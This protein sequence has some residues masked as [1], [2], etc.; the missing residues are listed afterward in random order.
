[1]LPATEA[2]AITTAGVTQPVTV[3]GGNGGGSAANQLNGASGVF[4]D[5][6]GDVYVADGGNNRV[7]EWAPGATSGVTVARADL[8]QYRGGTPPVSLFVD[9]SGDVYVPD[10]GNNR[11]QE[12]KPDGTSVTAA[13]VPFQSFPRAVFVDGSGDVYV[14]YG[15]GVQEW[16]PGATSGVTVIGGI[17]PQGL[18]VDGSGDVYVDPNGRLVQK[19]APGATSGVTVASG[20]GSSDSFSVDASGDVFVTDADGLQEW[21]PGA[22]SG[23]TVAPVGGSVFVDNSGDVYVDRGDRVQEWKI[24]PNGAP[25]VT[26]DPQSQPVIGG[27]NVSFNAGVLAS[28]I[29][30]VQWQ[31]STDGGSTWNDIS[32]ATSSTYTIFDT[33][34]SDNGYEFRA[35]FTNGA[36]SVATDPATLSVSPSTANATTEV[37]IPSTG[38][39]LSGT[40]AVL[41]ASASGSNGDTIANVGYTLTGGTN[42]QLGG[43]PAT[44]T[45]YGYLG[46]IDTTRFPNGTY[47]LQ[48]VATDS[49]GGTVYSPP[50]TVTVN[51]PTPTT[52]VLLPSNGSTVSGSVVLDAIASANA[53]QV[54]FKLDGQTIASA[55]GSLWGRYAIWNSA[56]VPNG[57]YRL[58]SFASPSNQGDPAAL[59]LVTG[60]SAPVTITVDN[61]PPMSSVLLPSNGATVSGGSVILDAVAAGNAAGNVTRVDFFLNGL[62]ITEAPYPSLWGWYADWNSAKVPN[63]TYTLQSE[64]FNA[65]PNVDM[66]APVTITVA[67]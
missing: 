2:S 25:Q 13:T 34:S 1:V 7:Q 8:Q 17:S 48:S 14:A 24:S 20:G 45:L 67:N 42:N 23:V 65:G 18:F 41:D 38:A 28:P 55:T 40:H 49:S 9:S 63:G 10:Y 64:A 22:T 4:V 47:T 51:N 56:T 66:S 30:A 44:P 3:A 54:G 12:W 5:S 46:V 11:V 16:A 15:G 6:S 36:G 39:D 50:V 29:P 53:Y 19:W 58:W 33:P 61:P 35:T 26:A 43:A 52:S 59:G 32:G 31:Q 57:T 60:T 21:A 37:L 27:H 62:W